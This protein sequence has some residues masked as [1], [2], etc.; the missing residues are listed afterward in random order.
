MQG[1]IKKNKAS[2]LVAGRRSYVDIFAKPFID[3]A[4][5]Y[6]YDLTA[7]VNYNLNDHNKL[8]LSGYF[9]R[10]VFKFDEEQGFDWG[11]ITGTLRWNHIFNNRLFSNFSFFVS[12]YDYGLAF[13]ENDRDKF[14]WDSRVLTYTFKPAFNYFLN[15]NNEVLFGGEATYYNFNPAEATVVSDGDIT[16]ISLTDRRALESALYIDNTQTVND[17]LSIKY[18]LRFSS[19]QYLGPGEVYEY[20]ETVPGERK[21]LVSSRTADDGEVIESYYNWEPRASV[22]YQIGKGSVKGSFTRTSQY[23]HLVSNTAAS[24]PIDIW[25]PST[26]NIKPQI[27]LQYALGYFRNFGRGNDYE[28]SVEAY[29]RDTDNQVEYV[30]GADL[31]INEYQEGD[32]ISGIGRAYGVEFNFKKNVGKL[33]G[34]ISYTLGRTELK[35]NGINRNDWYPTRFDQTHNLK[36][37]GNYDISKRVSASANFTFISGTPFSAPTSRFVIQNMV[38]PYDYYESRNGLRVPASH[39]LDLSVTLQMKREKKGKKR[40]NKDELVFSVYNVYGR[41]NPFSIFFA[42]Q[43][44]YITPG[45]N[46]STMAYRFSIVGAPVPAISY[47]FKF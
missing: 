27:G 35:V 19:Y 10:D 22:K 8:F 29:Y 15:A 16:D 36:V 13:G 26:N 21:T 3:D 14:E 20:E 1:P 31:F 4:T 44:G 17:K 34:W 2:F 25:T 41:R 43:D 28:A 33:N 37:F 45:D 38:I 46:V 24:T 12:T 42:Q 7:K 40:K 47:N 32:L 39:R 30:K 23:I 9:G 6:F 18:G 5:L 11:S